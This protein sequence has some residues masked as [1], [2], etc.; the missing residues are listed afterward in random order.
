MDSFDRVSALCLD[1]TEP[2][3]LRER[4]EATMESQ[5]PLQKTRSRMI[6]EGIWA[7]QAGDATDVIE[8]KMLVFYG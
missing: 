6:V 1:G 2:V 4:L 5:P 8:S 7:L 3:L